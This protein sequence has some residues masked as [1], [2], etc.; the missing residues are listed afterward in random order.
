[1][2]KSG[3]SIKPRRPPG[4]P[5]RSHRLSTTRKRYLIQWPWL[6]SL[7]RGLASAWLALWKWVWRAH[8]LIILVTT[9]LV[10]VQWIWG[11]WTL[12]ESITVPLRA[13]AILY[14]VLAAAAWV[15][16]RVSIQQRAHYYATSAIVYQELYPAAYLQGNDPANAYIMADGA[17]FLDYDMGGSDGGF[18]VGGGGDGD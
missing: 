6:K 8:I 10:I 12:P 3:R 4:Y 18:D 13:G 16:Y 17:G 2:T 9:P 15:I 1:M 14:W 7:S 11:F 5:P